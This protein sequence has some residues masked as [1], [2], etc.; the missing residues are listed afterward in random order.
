MY[1]EALDVLTADID[2]KLN[3]GHKILCRREV[4]DGLYDAVI[5]VEG[6]ADNVLAV[7][8]DRRRSYVESGIDLVDLLEKRLDYLN[9][10]SL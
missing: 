1:L 10:V 3:V 6:V 5:H 2:D 9:G 4:R 7:A 8:R